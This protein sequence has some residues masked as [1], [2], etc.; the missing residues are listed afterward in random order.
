MALAFFLVVKCVGSAP[1]GEDT[2]VD[3][4]PVAERL[5]EEEQGINQQEEL[6]L[7]ETSD[8]AIDDRIMEEMNGMKKE[9]DVALSRIGEEI[10]KD[11]EEQKEVNINR[12]K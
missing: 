9:F 3:C 6:D 12:K 11:Q 7:K 1:T 2:C 8:E 10:D 5:T 4:D